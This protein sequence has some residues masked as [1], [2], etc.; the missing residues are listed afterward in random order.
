MSLPNS[1]VS[2][3]FLLIGVAIPSQLWGQQATFP[4]SDGSGYPGTVESDGRLPV[5]ASRGGMSIGGP[6]G[7]VFGRGRGL[8]IGGPNGVQI[9]GGNGA[10][11]GGPEGVQLGNG[12]GLQF[13]AGTAGTPDRN[14]IGVTVGEATAKPITIE[15]PVTAS[16]QL[17]LQLD[18]T[19]LVVFPGET[20]EVNDRQSVRL[21]A[22]TP[23]DQIGVHRILTPGH[24]E[25]R[26]TERGWAPFRTAESTPLPPHPGAPPS[27]DPLSLPD[28]GN[29]QFREE[30]AR[31][32]QSVLVK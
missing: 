18:G 21:R 28:D 9:G 32:L 12:T 3:G 4:Q 24:H 15:Y 19:E 29:R 31:P 10:R 26:L 30:A 7:V 2:F 5:P 20:I 1:I 25:L 6:F 16:Q 11:F 17:R 13:G 27:L 22:P 23:E 8:S 14:S